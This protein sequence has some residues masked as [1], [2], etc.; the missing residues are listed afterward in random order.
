ML[1]SLRLTAAP[2]VIL[3]AL[4]SGCSIDQTQA[5]PPSP[6]PTPSLP[7]EPSP[8][9]ISSATP[10][11]SPQTDPFQDASD[12]AI[13]AVT[14]SKSAQ[15]KEDWD[16]V[17]NMWEEAIALM[18][19]V[20]TSSPN[21]AL[22]Q[23]K[24]IEYRRNLAN[25]MQQAVQPAP[26]PELIGVQE[27]FSIASDAPAAPANPTEMIQAFI[28]QYFDA[29]INKGSKGYEYWCSDFTRPDSVLS[30]VSIITPRSWEL[31][32]IKLESRGANRKDGRGDFIGDIIVRVESSN[33]GGTPIVN[34]W[35]FNVVKENP[36]LKNPFP[37]R[38]CI[39]ALSAN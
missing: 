39:T 8:S 1:K 27:P 21:Y 9:P 10:L 28:K 38:Y 17:I 32:N 30:P 2:F 34:N 25:V 6:T 31:L 14:I 13:G 5:T 24:V 3:L 22:A 33:S 20:P 12:K 19:S 7:L 4:M 15:S 16:S 18:K 26:S 36:K 11:P 35:S 37:G 29:T 23:K